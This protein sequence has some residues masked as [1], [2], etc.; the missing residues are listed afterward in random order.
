[1]TDEKTIKQS[2]YRVEKINKSLCDDFLQRH[3]YLAQQGNGFVGKVQ[4]GLFDH[5]DRFVGCIV[6]AG[7]SVIETLIGAFEGFERF[8]DQSGF[9]ELTRLAMDDEN[10]KKNLTSWFVAKTIK[11]LRREHQVRAI[12]SY[13]D[14]RYHHGYIYQ[15]TN[16]KYYGLAP[17]KN[18]FFQ[19]LPNGEEKQVW[20]GSVKGLEGEWRQRSRKHRYMIVYDDSLKIKWKEEPYPKGGNNVYELETPTS[21]QMTV[22]DYL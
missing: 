18:D 14:S 3:H 19:R 9:W 10:K 6:Y 16:F 2:G 7:I 11:Q 21:F 22:F 8:S 20:R 12:I 15:A 5:N 17:Q 4:Y 1:M 13:A